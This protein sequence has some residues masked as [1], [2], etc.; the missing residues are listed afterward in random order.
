MPTNKKKKGAKKKGSSNVSDWVRSGRIDAAK[1]SRKIPGVAEGLRDGSVQAKDVPGMVARATEED[2][3][4]RFETE[5]PENIRDL[6]TSGQKFQR[7]GGLEIMTGAEELLCDLI[8]V[9][10]GAD[11]ELSHRFAWEFFGGKTGCPWKNVK[12][13]VKRC[14]AVCQNENVAQTVLQQSARDLTQTAQDLAMFLQI[15]KA[16]NQT[17]ENFRSEIEQLAHKPM[18]EH[19]WAYK[20]PTSTNEEDLFI[21]SSE[22]MVVLSELVHRGENFSMKDLIRDMAHTTVMEKTPAIQ[23]AVKGIQQGHDTVREKCWECG[24]ETPKVYKCS[25]CKAARYCSKKCQAK[26]WK[27]GHRGACSNL[28]IMYQSFSENLNQIKEAVEAVPKKPCDKSKKELYYYYGQ[29]GN[30]LPPAGAFDYRLLPF[31]LCKYTFPVAFNVD[32]TQA[33]SIEFMYKSL[34]D[35]AKGKKHWMFDDTFPAPIQQYME[36]HPLEPISPL[37][38]DYMLQALLFLTIDIQQVAEGSLRTFH[39]VTHIMRKQLRGNNFDHSLM[40]VTRFIEVYYRLGLAERGG[41]EDPGYG[42]KCVAKTINTMIKHF[43]KGTGPKNLDELRDLEK[44]IADMRVL[45]LGL[46]DGKSYI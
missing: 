35:I 2:L 6:L 36:S 41:Y 37:E 42:L 34:D 23:A 1:L 27:E 39:A 13:A 43:H 19:V 22:F 45:P 15:Q 46:S 4:K 11:E 9:A 29:D 5:W 16:Y 28:K 26:S 30:S 20:K 44:D 40:P 18:E 12:E 21:A 3:M 10:V 33:S 7:L 25:C 14:D 38:A 24:T 17:C 8:R 31:M 32:F